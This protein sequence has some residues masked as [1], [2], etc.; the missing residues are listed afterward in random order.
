MYGSVN[1]LTNYLL[2]RSNENIWEIN[3]HELLIILVFKQYFP[4]HI[5]LSLPSLFLVMFRRI[6]ALSATQRPKCWKL[7]SFYVF[8]L[9]EFHLK[10][11]YKF[12][13]RVWYFTRVITSCSIRECLLVLM[14]CRIRAKIFHIN[15]KF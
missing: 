9:L 5:K 6:F 11:G 14:I 7:G 2:Q 13:E 8:Y 10:W 4:T 3:L 15:M 1:F 12:L